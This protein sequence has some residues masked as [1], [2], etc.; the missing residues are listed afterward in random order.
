MAKDDL[1]YISATE[2]LAQFKARKLSPVELMR[3]VIARAE[4]VEPA[5]NAFTFR[6][7]DEAMDRAKAAEAR[8]MKTDGRIRALEGIP[9]AV[10]DEH[11]IKGRV[12]SSAS[13]ITKDFVAAATSPDVERALRAGAI[14]HART[15][16]PE[17]SCLGQTWSRLWGVTRNPWNTE[18]T[19]GGSSGGS[20]ASLA[21]GT[22]TIASGSDIGGSIRIPASCCGVVGFKAPYGRNPQ[23]PPF[24]LDVYCHTGGLAR[25][26]ADMALYQNVIA[27]PHA[28]DIASI[29]PKLRIPDVAGLGGVKGWKVAYSIDLGYCEVDTDVAKN[30]KNA[31]AAFK[32]LGATVEPVDLG[33]SWSVLSTAMNHLNH[34]FGAYIGHHMRAHRWEMTTYARK[35]AEDSQ[36]STAE[37]F[38][39]SLTGAGE[40]YRTL[41]PIL[42]KYDV[43]ICPTTALPAVRA[44]LDPT[45]EKVTIN[46]REVDPVLG[47]VMTYPFNVMSRCPVM[48]VPTGHAANGVPTGMQ[49]VGRTYDDVRVF[50]AAAA[51][52]AAKP[53]LGPKARPRIDTKARRTK[54]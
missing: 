49:I 13:L 12:T 26:V 41:G 38:F 4:A 34:I 48:S 39:Q 46:G 1:C 51:F 24:N 50:R 52:E 42:D 31:I 44:D 9:Y 21:A 15:A 23:G 33:W 45:V 35:W 3:A 20:A 8:Y 16:T 17:F 27:G 32:S 30:T 36:R 18:F 14:V 54:Q 47:W 22:A 28:Q 7:Y 6:Y 2:A 29:R 37:D 19:P 5:I 43:F 25:T 11:W 53:W 10:K 40:M